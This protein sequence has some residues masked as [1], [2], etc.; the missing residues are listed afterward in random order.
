MVLSHECLVLSFL[1]TLVLQDYTDSLPPALYQ[2]HYSDCLFERPWG[3]VD[4]SWQE[5]PI[6]PKGAFCLCRVGQAAHQPC[7]SS[8]LVMRA[9]AA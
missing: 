1:A 2:T 5:F 8:S 3:L 9:Y 4:R 6:H 7:S